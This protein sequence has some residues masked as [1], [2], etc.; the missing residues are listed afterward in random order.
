MICCLSDSL[1]IIVLSLLF[2]LPCF[3][4][5]SQSSSQFPPESLIPEFGQPLP[6]IRQAP[7]SD[8]R[9][10]F[11]SAVQSWGDGQSL[12]EERLTHLEKS[13]FGASYPEHDPLSRLEHLEKELTGALGF[14]SIDDRLRALETKLGSQA[15]FVPV[16]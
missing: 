10:T 9:S 8:S 11:N 2:V 5:E 16:K 6:E 14:G 12:R 13:A 1:M 3:A 15:A 7:A 4:D